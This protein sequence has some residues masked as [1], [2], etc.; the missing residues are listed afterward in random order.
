MTESKRHCWRSVRMVRPRSPACWRTPTPSS[1]TTCR[2][3]PTNPAYPFAP[4]GDEFFTNGCRQSYII[5]LSDGEPNLDL[6]PYCENGNG[7]CPFR[8]PHVV[9]HELASPANPDLAVK[10]FTIGFGLS[11]GSGIDCNTLDPAT[12]FA[13]GGQCDGATGALKACCSLMRVAYEG[14]TK[15]AFFADNLTTLKTE[16]SKI[17]ELISAESTS[18]TIPAFA[19]AASTQAS[20]SDAPAVA[21]E[22]TS[23]FRPGLNSLWSGNL[24][25]HRWECKLQAGV[26]LPELQPVIDGKGDN[27]AGKRQHRQIDQPTRVHHLY[28]QPDQQ[29]WFYHHRLP[30]DHSAQF[31]VQ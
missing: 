26:L 16:L 28:R 18:R 4:A 19:G 15:R 3:D 11:A 10:T 23:S 13:N 1:V 31:G 14:G 8:E 2:N 12:D 9:A 22:F 29:R 24:E 21:Y 17:L 20:S 27:F 30:W 6:R 5:L 25:R 7:S